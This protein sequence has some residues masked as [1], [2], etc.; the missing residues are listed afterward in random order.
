MLCSLACVPLSHST[1]HGSAVGGF[2]LRFNTFGQTVRLCQ[3][4]LQAHLL[5]DYLTEEFVELSVIHIY[6]HPHPYV[7]PPCTAMFAFFRWLRLLAT[8]AWATEPL[9][10]SINGAALDAGTARAT[11][12]TSGVT[13]FVVTEYDGTSAWTRSV[14]PAVWQR[15]VALA[16]HAQ[17]RVLPDAR[18]VF[19]PNYADYYALVRVRETKPLVVVDGAPLI[20]FDALRA[21]VGELRAAFD[22]VALFFYDGQGGTVVGVVLRPG[23]LRGDG[24][25]AA[26]CVRPAPD[27]S[28]LQW[29][30]EDFARRIAAIG[31]RFVE[32]VQLVK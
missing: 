6:T 29:S 15:T 23:V 28:A 31:E 10:V 1:V 12:R 19:G 17:S 32:S 14:E 8:Y 30:F 18:A 9:L 13:P 26:L 2:Q 16:S 21:F 7:R 27:G 22:A 4:W 24:N 11:M 5:T 3:R 20:G 25:P